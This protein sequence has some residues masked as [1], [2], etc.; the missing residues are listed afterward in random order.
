[1]RVLVAGGGTGGHLYPG[2]AVARELLRRDPAAAVSFVGTARGIESRVVPREGFALDLIRVSGLK[3]MSRLNRARGALRLPLAG[4]DAWRVITRRRPDVVVGVGG[5]ASGPVVMLAALRGV[6]TMLLEQNAMP[7]LTNRLL[8]R[9]VRAAAV[10]FEES[11]RFFPRTGFVAGNPVRP[12]FFTK[13]DDDS[14]DS[15][16]RPAAL[17]QGGGDEAAGARVLIFGGSQGAHA[18]NV[19]MVEAAARLAAA[20]LRVAITHQTGERDLDLVRDAYQRAGLAARVEAFIYEMDREMKQASLVVARSGAT[21]LAELAAA[22]RPAVLIPLPTSTDDHQRSNAAA[23]ARAGAAVVIDERELTA[24]RLAAEI[25]GLMADDKRR[26]AMAAAARTLARP[27][28][29]A[30]IVDRMLALAGGA[31]V[32]GVGSRESGV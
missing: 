9:W 7:G 23:V 4:V 13:E 11:L 21:T 2:I 18:I 16:G 12:E 25:R 28:A 27:D 6:P 10:N 20:G 1:V 30:R 3:G 14:V 5:F 29:A 15:G 8:A 24:D 26:A 22:G 31:S 19:A 32:S 17:A